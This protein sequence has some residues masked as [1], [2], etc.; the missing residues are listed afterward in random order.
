M[1]TTFISKQQLNDLDAC[2]SWMESI[3]TTLRHF[4]NETAP[5]GA[6]IGTPSAAMQAGKAQAQAWAKKSNPGVFSAIDKHIASMQSFARHLV[7]HFEPWVNTDQ[8]PYLVHLS[9]LPLPPGPLPGGLSPSSTN[10]LELLRYYEDSLLLLSEIVKAWA[11]GY[12]ALREGIYKS[13]PRVVDYMTVRLQPYNPQ[14][15]VFG[16]HTIARQRKRATREHYALGMTASANFH[17]QYRHITLMLGE[18]NGHFGDL[19][20]NPSAHLFSLDLQHVMIE[21]SRVQQL[22]RELVTLRTSR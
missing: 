18:A 9:R 21:L 8:R 12:D 4:N 19:V 11:P 5:P 2:M 15:K 14:S 1:S 6:L 17:A 16:P 20:Q 3:E 7:S 22:C 13:L 10:C